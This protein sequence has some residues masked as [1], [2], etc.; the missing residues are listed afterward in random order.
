VNLFFDTSALV[1]VF[2][3]EVG[4]DAV[5]EL[6]QGDNVNL[7]ISELAK[8]ELVSALHRRLRMHEL[9]KSE[10]EYLLDIIEEELRHF[11]IESLGSGVLT[12][13]ERLIKVSSLNCME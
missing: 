10:L 1:K 12:E 3:K 4:S 8:L 7:W 13:A 9:K 6:I 2:Q 11:Q 5:I